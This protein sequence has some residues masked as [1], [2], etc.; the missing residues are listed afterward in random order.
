MVCPVEQAYCLKQAL[1]NASLTI[2]EQ[3]GHIAT[4]PG[5]LSALIDATNCFADNFHMKTM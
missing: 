4:E 2:V 3:A 1:P 5:I